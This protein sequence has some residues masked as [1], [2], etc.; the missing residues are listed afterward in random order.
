MWV[1]RVGKPP[2]DDIAQR[3]Q[4][5]SGLTAGDFAAVAAQAKIVGARW[6]P[7]EWLA[8]LEKEVALRPVSARAVG[9]NS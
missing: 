8:A 2:P 9:F 1:R 4:R 6:G 7:S 3:L 5:V